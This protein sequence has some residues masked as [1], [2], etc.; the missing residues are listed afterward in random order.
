M[1]VELVP[2]APLSLGWL[3]WRDAAGALQL[4]VIAKATLEVRPDHTARIVQ[5]YPL[6][7]DIHFEENAGRSLRVASDFAPRKARADVLFTGAAYAPVGEHVTHRSIRLAMAVA[8]KSLFDRRLLAIGARERDRAGTPM[9]PQ[10]FAY[11]PLRWELAYGGGSSP[12]NPIGVGA[13]PAD[14]RLPSIVDSANPKKAAGLG[15]I[16]PSWQAR[17]AALGGL[18]PAALSRPTPTLPTAFDFAYFNAAPAEQQLP[19]LRGDEQVLMSGLHPTLADIAW[20]LPGMRAHASLELEGAKHDVPLEL[21]T[22]WIEGETLRA[23]LTWRGS[24]AVAESDAPRLESGRVL[25][26]LAKGDAAPSWERRPVARVEPPSLQL[27][28]IPVPEASSFLQ[29]SSAIELEMENSVLYAAKPAKAPRLPRRVMP[30]VPLVNDSGLTAWTLP[31]Q[32][33]PPEYVTAVIVKATFAIGDDGTLVQSAEQD[34]PSGDVP[35]EGEAA[36]AAAAGGAAGSLRYTSD[37]AIFKPAADVLLVGHAYPQDPKVGVSNVE[38]VVG[39][40]R[41]RLTVFGERVWAGTGFEGKAARFEKLPL[42]WEHA[43]GGPLAEANPVGRPCKLGVPPPNL[44]RPE[45]L[46]GAGDAHP[47]PACTAPVSPAWKG[48]SAKVG[49]YDAAWLKERWPYLPAD[50]DWS[51]FNAAP[52]E[53]QVPYLRGDERYAILGVRPGGKGYE[54]R[55]PGLRPRVFAQQTEAAGGDFFEVLLRLDTVWFDTDARKLVLVWRGLYATPDEDSPDVA[56]LFVDVEKGEST[57]KLED[58]RVR[59]LARAAVQGVLPAAALAFPD[60]P[61]GGSAPDG[62]LLASSRREPGPEPVRRAPLPTPPRAPSREALLAEVAA[63]RSLAG[64]DLTGAELAGANLAG[65]DLSRAVLAG[66]NLTEA[67]LDGAKLQGAVLTRVQADRASFVGAD[68]TEAD[69][70][71]AS[72][73]GANLGKA[74]LPRASL[75]HAN[76]TGIHLVDARAERATFGGATLQDAKLDRA[77][78]AGADFTGATLVGASFREAALDDA[79][80]YDARADGAAFDKASMERLRADRASLRGATLTGITGPQSVWESADLTGATLQGAKLPESIFVRAKLDEA[81]L[82]RATA[83]GAN[84]QRASLKRARLARANLMNARFERADLTEADLRG[85]NLHQVETWRA[86]TTQVDLSGANV[87]GSKLAKR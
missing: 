27:G 70:T 79:R 57:A 72:L 55:L 19:S 12:D 56:A 32:I 47:A 5:P 9:P 69:L 48:R 63:G 64:K 13:D 4:T 46:I 68:L 85:A 17:R 42:R 65:V 21:D 1:P 50:F 29:R 77:R 58:A 23:T 8:G 11:L 44:E 14:P 2:L 18:D 24:V 75:D 30:S 16:P 53:Q 83:T 54:G 26:T 7:G 86:K 38:L 41:R 43:L 66:A 76:A 3:L 20:R 52:I 67:V 84:F 73:V 87:T 39:N 28:P 22:L 35:W 49:T 15:P 33:K 80:L 59:S 36:E 74:S 78:L 31:W 37:F 10:P 40:L 45:Q 61:P 51:Y 62:A 6:F 81:T 71:G 25:T 82:D 60:E 34:P